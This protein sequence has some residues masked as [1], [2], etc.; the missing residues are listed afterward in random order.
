LPGFSQQEPGWRNSHNQ[1]RGGYIRGPNVYAP[2]GRLIGRDPSLN[3][4]QQM[5]DE[6][7]RLR[8][9]S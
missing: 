3:V 7:L 5:Y 6:D 8:R 4:R 9:G 1:Y 2:S